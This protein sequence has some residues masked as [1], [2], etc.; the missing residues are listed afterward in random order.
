MDFHIEQ[1]QECADKEPVAPDF[2]TNGIMTRPTRFIMDDL[3]VLSTKL[4]GATL[5]TLA[6][7]IFFINNLLG[8]VSVHEFII[9]I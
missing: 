7:Y 4:V 8:T 1:F 6:K 2:E 5:L 9:T 3:I